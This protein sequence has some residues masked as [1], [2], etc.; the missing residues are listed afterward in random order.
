VTDFEF[1]DHSIGDLAR[2][3]RTG[4]LSPVVITESFLNRIET[5]DGSLGAFQLVCPDRALAAARA[6]E[7]SLAAGQDLGPL[8]GIP[9]A[10][11]DLFDVKGLPT[12]AGTRLLSDNIADADAAVVARLARAGMILVGKT[13]TVQFA[14]GGAGIN[15]DLGTPH[16]PW[17]RTHHLPGGSSSGSAVAVAAGMA[18]AALGS[19]TGGS[20]RIPAAL[21]GITGLKTTVGQVSR[22]GVYPLS[23]SL[24]SVGPLT[25][26]A[27]DAA[28]LY[29][30]MQGP[31]AG[32][33]T[34]HGRPLQ[35]VMARLG[36]GVEGLRIGIAETVFWDDAHPEV[37][38]AVRSATEVFADNG[39]HVR[40][41]EF[42]AAA[43]AVA[44]N[45]RGLVIAA[46]AYTINRRFIDEHYEELDPIVAS[47]MVNG[48]DISAA[49]YLQTTFAWKRLRAE[50]V[51]QLM[52]FDAVLC[53]TTPIPACT[54]AEANGDM[55]VY[56]R[57]NLM[58][59][60][61]TAIGNIL[62]LC[63]L[64]VPCGFTGD[65]LP[66]GLMIYARPFQEDK[67]LRI[68]HA[69]Q[70]ATE[71][72]LRRPDLEWARSR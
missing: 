12:T 66:I 41:V 27:E 31:D 3:L 69:Y 57:K 32:D 1:H 35:D 24:D 59:L 71:W 10:A 22:A 60:R 13:K 34:T 48:R 15:R 51:R 55:D 67:V 16:N 58:Y 9:Y 47:R 43:D 45:P 18:P 6:A 25:R 46:E 30:V 29:Q 64:S 63:G 39:A 33:D 72:H 44:L 65:G 68:G 28:L 62:D 21:C 50:A 7:A 54:L 5:L 11:K 38:G 37:T 17:H 56:S 53:P 52:D 49:D 40:S 36:D 8:H 4:E 70:Q 2:R 20:V 23:W 14:Y 42:P 61:N 19:D 26:S